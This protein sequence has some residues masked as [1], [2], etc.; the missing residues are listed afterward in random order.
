MTAPATEPSTPVTLNAEMAARYGRLTARA[1]RLRGRTAAPNRERWL[2][3]GGGTAV[4]LG[5]L[6]VTLGWLGASRTV[7]VFEQLPYLISGGI[8]GGCLVIA[9]GLAYF[10][11]WIT[12]VTAEVRRSRETAERSVAALERVEA[13][14]TTALAPPAADSAAVEAPVVRR[15]S[16]RARTRTA[17]SAGRAS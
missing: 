2:V 1:G 12:Q 14:L 5:F 9:G 11:F 3:V 16:P 7:L 15:P 10:A 13:L 8:F 17:T 6:L 4:S